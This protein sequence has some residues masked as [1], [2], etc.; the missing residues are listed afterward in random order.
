MVIS[1]NQIDCLMRGQK[2]VLPAALTTERQVLLES[3]DH[4]TTAGH[5]R[6]PS[7]IDE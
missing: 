6:H 1:H 4:Q 7:N 5:N 2:S 3:F